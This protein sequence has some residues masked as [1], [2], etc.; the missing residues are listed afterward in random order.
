M[1]TGGKGGNPAGEQDNGAKIWSAPAIHPINASKE[2]K[3]SHRSDA[4]LSPALVT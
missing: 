2:S 3:L 4:I 1:G